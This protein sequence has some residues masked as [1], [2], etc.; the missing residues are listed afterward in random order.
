MRDFYNKNNAEIKRTDPAKDEM[1]EDFQFCY[2]SM[3]ISYSCDL[4]V[5]EFLRSIVKK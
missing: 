5:P 3:P 4:D 2:L 1:R